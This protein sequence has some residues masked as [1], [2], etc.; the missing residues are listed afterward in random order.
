MAC[1][2]AGSMAEKLRQWLRPCAAQQAVAPAPI[3]GDPGFAFLFDAANTAKNALHELRSN[4]GCGGVRGVDFDAQYAVEPSVRDSSHGMK[5]NV[6]RCGV[7]ELACGC[8]PGIKQARGLQP[9]LKTRPCLRAHFIS[10][11]AQFPQW[12]SG[13]RLARAFGT[14][15]RNYRFGLHA[16]HQA[17]QS[18]N[19]LFSG[20]RLI[21]QRT[22]ASTALVRERLR[23]VSMSWAATSSLHR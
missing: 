21:F 18:C 8:N 11:L 1:I 7:N 4:G 10:E 5:E 16:G 19:C 9:C 15:M 22:R 6:M 14:G 20:G 23:R 3:V 17:F 12:S 13:P 2:L